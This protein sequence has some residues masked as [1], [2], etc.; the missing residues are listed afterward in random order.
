MPIEL[1]YNKKLNYV[2]ITASGNATVKEAELRMEEISI[3]E[4]IPS[5]VNSLWDMRELLFDHID[6]D[7]IK[8]FTEVR[9]KYNDVRGEAKIALLSNS[10]LAAPLIKLYTILSRDLC[11][12]YKVFKTLEEAE[13]WLCAEMLKGS[14]SV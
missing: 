10:V 9:K 4:V 11:Q 8:Q 5:N 14:E 12:K 1:E 3:S 6:M 2:L 7:F 13:Q